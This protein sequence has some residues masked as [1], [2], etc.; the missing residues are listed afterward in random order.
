MSILL[1]EETR[2]IVQG[3]TGR[4]GQVQV[5]WM[6][7]YGTNIVAGVTPGQ[8]GAVVHGVPVYDNVAEAVEKEGADATVL[9]VPAPY[10]K[11]AVLEAIAAGI[12]LVVAVPEHVPVHD[13]MAMRRAA[14]EAGVWLLGPNTPGIISPGIGKL[15][16]MPGNMFKPGRIG[17]ISRS[18]TLAYE[19]AGYVNEAG[20]GESTLL[21]IGGDPVIGPDIPDIL[22][23]FEKDPGTDAVVLVGE[24]GGS[25]EEEAAPFIA[26][27]QKPVVA[28]IAGRSAPPGR[29][30]GHAGAIIRAGQGTVQDKTRALSAAGAAVATAIAEVPRLLGQRLQGRTKAR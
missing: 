2:A 15:G 27:M 21:G 9:F 20:Y 5:R 14:R 26:R 30:M 3:A 19:V 8:G 4:I 18:G 10:T 17:I 16:I 25:A 28:Y 22:A 11:D 29:R 13:A 7:E 12:R 6:L 24:I 1:T 23:A